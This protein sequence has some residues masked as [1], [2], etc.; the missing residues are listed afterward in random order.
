MEKINSSKKSIDKDIRKMF[1]LAIVLSVV[2]VV[3]IPL[4]IISA[5]N[6]TTVVLILGI[7]M[8]VVGFYGTPLAWIGYGNIRALRRVVDAV[9]EEHLTT[10]QE[11]A[12]HLQISEKS[13][14]ENITK[15]INK[16]YITG[17]LY[18][19]TAL[20]VNQKKAPAKKEVTATNICS[21]CGAQMEVDKNGMRCLYCGTKF[22][23]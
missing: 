23:K 5:I 17:Y 22:A 16:K 18:D 1:C 10:N 4:L 11:I 9:M 2:F 15:A 13:A 3:G 6:G 14:K 19:G 20:T 7:L 12:K 8:V 21:R